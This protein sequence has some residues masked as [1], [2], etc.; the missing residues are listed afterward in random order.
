MEDTVII[1]GIKEEEKEAS[2]PNHLSPL[3]PIQEIQL[4]VDKLQIDMES[5]KRDIRIIM[6]SVN[7]QQQQQSKGWWW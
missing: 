3:K 6:D 4:K 1:S 2:R 7:H 5:V